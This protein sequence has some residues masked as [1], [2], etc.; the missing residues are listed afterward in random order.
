MPSIAKKFVMP[1]RT[2]STVWQYFVDN[3]DGEFASCLLCKYHPSNV[4]VL[5]F[6]VVGGSEDKKT[7]TQKHKKIKRQKDKKT[8]RQEDKKAVFFVRFHI[9]CDRYTSDYAQFTFSDTV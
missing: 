7:K 4:V 6:M 9:V 2:S 3:N 1:K 5:S 8:K